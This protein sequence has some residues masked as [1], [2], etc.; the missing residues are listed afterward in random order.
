M[1]IQRLPTWLRGGGKGWVI[2]ETPAAKEFVIAKCGALGFAV[3]TMRHSDPAM[4]TALES[5]PQTLQIDPY[6]AA[7]KSATRAAVA[8]GGETTND[9]N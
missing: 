2:C 9:G 5:F 7:A 1:A 4:S 3:E 6:T 8:G